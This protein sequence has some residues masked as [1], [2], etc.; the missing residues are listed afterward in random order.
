MPRI[1]LITAALSL[2]L[3]IPS[4][5]QPGKQVFEWKLSDVTFL[6]VPCMS[7]TCRERCM[8]ALRLALPSTGQEQGLVQALHGVVKQWAVLLQGLV[9]LLVKLLVWHAT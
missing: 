4:F 6:S 7:Y 1:A 3:F 9:K 2:A 8:Q 5:A